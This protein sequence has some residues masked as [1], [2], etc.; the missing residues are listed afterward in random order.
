MKTPA[1][2][3]YKENNLMYS[4][5]FRSMEAVRR[6]CTSIFRIIIIAEN[7]INSYHKL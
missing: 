7:R 3:L 2:F 4:S 6:V 1:Q 5:C